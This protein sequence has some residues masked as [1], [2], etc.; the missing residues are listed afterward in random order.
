MCSLV[1]NEL[2]YSWCPHVLIDMITTV[3]ILSSKKAIWINLFSNHFKSAPKFLH[4][5]NVICPNIE[6]FLSALSMLS[7]FILM[8]LKD[9]IFVAQRV[10]IFLQHLSLIIFNIG[11]S[12]DSECILQS[13]LSC[14]KNVFALIYGNRIPYDGLRRSVGGLGL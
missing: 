7:M 12:L 10:T 11:G 1:T 5:S 13:T 2:F 4:H 14:Y 9:Q 8:T 3:L 6:T